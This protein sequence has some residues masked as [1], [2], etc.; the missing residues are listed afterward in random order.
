MQKQKFRNVTVPWTQNVVAT[1]SFDLFAY[2]CQRLRIIHPHK[3]HPRTIYP[4]IIQFGIIHH[5]GL[6]N[7]GLFSHRIIHFR[8]I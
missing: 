1:S 3:V 6:I 5:L 7:P 8:T 2:G 4:W